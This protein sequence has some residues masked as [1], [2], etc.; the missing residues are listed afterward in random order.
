MTASRNRNQSHTRLDWCEYWRDTCE[1]RVE[2][3]CIRGVLDSWQE[4]WLYSLVVDIIPVDISEEGLAHHFLRICRAA[5]QSLIRL[6]GQEFLQ[7][8]HGI[9]GHVDRVQRFISKDGIVDF[10]LILAS[11]WRLLQK[12]LINQHTKCPPVY[13][14]SV[15]LVKQNLASQS[16]TVFHP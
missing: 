10:V 4:W 15:F 8:G 9:P 14:P 13:S 16:V 6:A 1:L 12:H 7:N 2:I 11:E 3:A 5:P